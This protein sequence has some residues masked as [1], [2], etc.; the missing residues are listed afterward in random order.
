MEQTLGDATLFHDVV[1]GFKF[2]VSIRVQGLIDDD[3]VLQKSLQVFLA[4]FTE[5]EAV[6]PWT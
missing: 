3:V 1:D 2:V 5:E 4:I 6:D